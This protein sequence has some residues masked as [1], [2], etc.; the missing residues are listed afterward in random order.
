VYGSSFVVDGLGRYAIIDMSLL[1]LLR[2]IEGYLKATELPAKVSG[3]F[4]FELQTFFFFL[5][6]QK[7]NDNL[8]I[9]PAQ[10]FHLIRL[11]RAQIL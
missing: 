5:F 8:L 3:G 1:H 7:L 11:N 10:Y 9:Y 4:L 2:V 6:Q